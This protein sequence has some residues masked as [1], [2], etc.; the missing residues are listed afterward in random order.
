MCGAGECSRDTGSDLHALRWDEPGQL[1]IGLELS[2]GVGGGNRLAILRVNTEGGS[3]RADLSGSQVDG[4]CGLGLHMVLC[5][6]CPFA[7]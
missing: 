6:V 7:R 1:G 3:G 2:V 5:V 4:G